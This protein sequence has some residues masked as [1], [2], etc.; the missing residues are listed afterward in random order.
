MPNGQDDE[1]RTPDFTAAVESLDVFEWAKIVWRSLLAEVFTGAGRTHMRAFWIELI[2]VGLTAGINLFVEAG[3]FFADAVGKGEIRQDSAFQRLMQSGIEDLFGVRIDLNEITKAGA[4][5]G[6]EA[7]AEAIGDALLRA[8]TGSATGMATGAV[9]PTD[10]PAKQFLAMVAGLA[11]EGWLWGTVSSMIPFGIL[12]KFADLD[13]IMANVL[14]LGR[15]SRAVVNPALQALV[16]TPFRWQ[17]NKTSRPTLLPSTTAIAQMV[18]GNMPAEDAHEEL[19]RL[20]FSPERIELLIRQVTRVP[21]AGDL[22]AAVRAGLITE[23]AAIAGF[24]QIGWDA[25]G[26]AFMRTLQRA[27][28]VVT[29]Q[30]QMGADIANAFVAGDLTE[31]DLRRFMDATVTDPTDRN[32]GIERAILRRGIFRRQLGEGDVRDALQRGIWGKQ[33][34]RVWL[35]EVGY[36]DEDAIVKEQLLDERMREREDARLERLRIKGERDEAAEAK[37]AEAEARQLE[38]DEARAVFTLPTA[39]VE[40]AA[41]SGLISMEEYRAY[42]ATQRLTENDRFLIFS[43]A[44]GKREAQLAKEAAR[45]EREA[46]L[47]S[48]GISL[49][50]LEQAIL[51]GLATINDYVEQLKAQKID[52]EGIAILRT[53]LEARIEAKRVAKEL[54]DEAAAEL[55]NKGLSLGQLERAVRAGL[56][57]VD[58]YRAFL[59]REGFNIVTVATLVDLLNQQ[60]ARDQAA[61]DAAAEREADAQVKRIGLGDLRT[62]V[63]AGL[64]P[65]ADYQRALDREGLPAA[66]SATLIA[67][68]QRQIDAVTAREAAE[69]DREAARFL[70]GFSEGAL[71]QALFRDQLSLEDYLRALPS[72]GFD[73]DAV[74]LQRELVQL[75]LDRIADAK[76][77]EQEAEATL[78]AVGLSRGEVERAVKAGILPLEEYEKLLERKGLTEDARQVLVDLLVIELQRLA[79]ARE[80]AAEIAADP[81]SKPLKL[82]E[83]RALIKKGLRTL[84]DYRAALA[85]GGYSQQDG[86]DLTELLQIQLGQ[87]DTAATIRARVAAELAE[88]EI[89]LDEL[90]AFVRNGRVTLD[91][92]ARFLRAEGY[93]VED[94]APLVALLVG[95]LPAPEVNPADTVS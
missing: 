7:A 60:L 11:I 62:A 79:A 93:G 69:A 76:A 92:Y 41:V 75:E 9:E 28:D 5:G 4:S 91:D 80:R 35:S 90:E 37:R 36:T 89:D 72:R 34:Y 82:G 6:R 45:A 49:G 1:P 84:D 73:P 40:R 25:E 63:I 14:G 65:L 46:A 30:N 74:T 95:S 27:R 85:R 56:R 81:V 58:E 18:R 38:I 3:L 20:G 67:L 94:V 12:N 8:V 54:A 87:R 13:D 68:L 88:L 83:L 24:R 64:R 44:E 15:I 59:V 77:Q 16:I 26:A 31:A 42:L 71:R 2:S 47:A 10:E 17:V 48:K 53:L 61:R 23:D 29:F 50:Q 55:R 66:D 33:D 43:L 57:P 78:E 39:K 52:D 19:A 32:Q 51:A 86:D 70:R 22:D 21:G